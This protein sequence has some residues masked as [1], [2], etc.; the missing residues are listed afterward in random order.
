[1]INWE[2]LRHIHVIRKL[3]SMMSLWFQTDILFV[4]ERGQVRNFDVLDKNRDLKNPLSSV[5]LNKEKGRE[6]VFQ[7]AKEMNEKVFRGDRPSFSEQ[8]PVGCEQVVVSRIAIDQEF[9]GSVYA[10]CYTERAVTPEAREQAKSTAVQLGF[11]PESFDQAV[12]GLKILTVA[13]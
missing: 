10:F 9:L 2:E 1:M 4:D 12:A 6:F 11:E 7:H 3:Q 13:D 5:L 8:G